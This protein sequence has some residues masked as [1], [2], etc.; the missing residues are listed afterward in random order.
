M[1]KMDNVVR[2]YRGVDP[3]D[4]EPFRMV[5]KNGETAATFD[6]NDAFSRLKNG[7]WCFDSYTH[8][9]PERRD[10]RLAAIDQFELMW[11]KQE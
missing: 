3:V 9:S 8:S 7:T 10:K 6:D 11:E 1:V 5:V 2:C 4:G